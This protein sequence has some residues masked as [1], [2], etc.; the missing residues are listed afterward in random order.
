MMLFCSKYA[1]FSASRAEFITDCSEFNF[2]QLNLVT[3]SDG[4]STYLCFTLTISDSMISCIMTGEQG[5]AEILGQTVI[6]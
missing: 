1:F 5:Q 4:L 2:S 3:C 6:F